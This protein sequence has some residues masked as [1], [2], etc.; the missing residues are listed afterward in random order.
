MSVRSTRVI[1]RL[2]QDDLPIFRPVRLAALRDHPE[3]FGS[4]FEEEQGSLDGEE[5]KADGQGDAMSRLIAEP[6]GVTLGGF[7][8]GRLVATGCMTVSVRIKQRHKGHLSAVYVSPGFRGTGLAQGIQNG[9][10]EQARAAGLSFLTLSVTV[11]NH[12]A[13]ALYQSAGFQAYGIEPRSLRIG[14]ELFDEE[15]MLLRLD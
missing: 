6:P 4:S 10:I 3:A 7:T 12:S 5:G 13:R 11:G 15:L 14:S 2:T 1:R 8:D 9:L